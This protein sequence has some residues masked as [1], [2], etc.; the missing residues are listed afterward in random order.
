MWS[1]SRPKTNGHHS[2]VGPKGPLGQSRC[3]NPQTASTAPFR[4]DS[5]LIVGSAERMPD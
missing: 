3:L 5:N 1:V 2:H 4:D